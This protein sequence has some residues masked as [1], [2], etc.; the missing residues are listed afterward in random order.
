MIRRFDL[1]LRAGLIAACTLMAQPALSAAVPKPETQSW[2]F[3]GPLGHFDKGQLQRGFKV[4]REV[5]ASCHSLN[6]VAF[7]NLAEEGGPGFTEG[8]VKNLANEYKVQDGPN[9]DG[10]MFERPGTPADRF[11]KVF[12]N[13]QAARA[14]NGGAYPPDLSLMAKARTYERGFPHF[15]ID[16]VTQYQELGP[17]YLY[18]LLTGYVE[19]PEGE[20]EKPGLHY[21]KQFP[22]HW[23]AMAKPL[24]DGQ[25]EYT[26]GSPATVDQYARDVV[27]FM[28]WTAEP[29]LEARK[30][31]GLISIIFL[32]VLTTL[33]Y[34][35]KKRV[36]KNV[37]YRHHPVEGG[38]VSSP[39]ANQ[40]TRHD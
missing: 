24:S 13:E 12:P 36:W 5:C 15:L 30:R 22:G 40:T 6:L 10:E 29:H 1:A 2:T 34:F 27:A 3:A 23:I 33:L 21:N 16:I 19:K 20:E 31:L 39:P 7:R 35:T 8:Q 9:D 38:N 37:A 4:Y 25:V 26:D 28:M 17:D 32:I 18:T 11:P 14:A